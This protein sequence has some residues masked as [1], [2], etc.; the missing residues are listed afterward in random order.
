[1]KFTLKQKREIVLRFWK[2]ETLFGITTTMVKS[3]GM[4]H[5]GTQ[6]LEEIL[7]DYLNREFRMIP[8]ERQKRPT[9]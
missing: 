3:G 9:R 1:M 5:W 7:R 8:K 2:G 6:D 4:V